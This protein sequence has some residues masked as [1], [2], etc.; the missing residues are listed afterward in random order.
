MNALSRFM[1]TLK[2]GEA[3]LFFSSVSRF[4]LTG[5]SSSDGVLLV[6]EEGG[7][8][9]LDSRYFEMACLR[10]E[11]GLLPEKLN[12]FPYRFAEDFKALTEKGAFHSVFFED[13]EMTVREFETLE[14]RFPKASFVPLGSRL[15]KMRVVK[16]PE[17]ISRIR[18]SQS[19]AEKAY[20]YILP[21]LEVGRSEREIAAEIEY[22]MKRN[23]AEGPSFSTIC[24]SGTRSSL[25]HGKPTDAL[26]EKG[27]FITMDFGCVL[28]GYASDMTR[29]VALGK[30]S[31]KM[32]RVYDTVLKAQEAAL[33]SVRG[34][35]LGKTVDEAAR[36]VIRDAGFGE[37]FGHSTGHG[38]GLRVHESPSFAPRSEEVIPAGA[39][40][41]VEPGIYLPGEFGVRIEDLV[42]VT[43]KG[44]ENL[45][46][47]S[48]ILLE[49]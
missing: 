15:E 14:R 40:L 31:E 43:E 3:A 2:K 18:A 9:Y 49:L 45:N 23:G 30:A 32:R 5:F 1:N 38:L 7:D 24:V 27:V 28:D 44:M 26:L 10:K 17:E 35:V 48:K 11:K 25:P 36:A 47:S 41:S 21:R 19:L 16:T 4:Y 39:V 13:L 46:S 29:T 6:T 20:E 12:V 8:L 22:F 42:V 37:Y 34:G 33:S